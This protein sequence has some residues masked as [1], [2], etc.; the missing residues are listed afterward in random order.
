MTLSAPLLCEGLAAL[1][2]PGGSRKGVERLLPVDLGVH[3]FQLDGQ[4]LCRSIRG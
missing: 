1:A 4:I 3:L 2:D